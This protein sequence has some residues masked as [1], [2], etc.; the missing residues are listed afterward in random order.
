MYKQ[1]P[2]EWSSLK[3]KKL[4]IL[5][6]CLF[7]LSPTDAFSKNDIKNANQI[8]NKETINY[9]DANISNTLNVLKTKSSELEPEIYHP[10]NLHFEQPLISSKKRRA[11]KKALFLKERRSRSF[12]RKSKKLK[13]Y[14]H[15]TE[16][17]TKDNPYLI[18]W[19][20]NINFKGEI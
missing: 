14:Y 5:I 12:E 1:H 20:R 18:T 7:I 10:M 4:I 15:T 19:I 9:V 6:F 3:M 16:K 11:K 13:F 2:K 17:K 8:H